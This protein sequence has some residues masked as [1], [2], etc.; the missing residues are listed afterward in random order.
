MPRNPND[1]LNDRLKSLQLTENE[2]KVYYFIREFDH[3]DDQVNDQL[4]TN[5]IS[6][7]LGLSYSTIQRVLRVL[8]QKDMVQRVGSKKTGS[9]QVKD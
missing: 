1:R 5:Y 4:T 7:K 8:K 2:T 6:Q 3:V 9:W